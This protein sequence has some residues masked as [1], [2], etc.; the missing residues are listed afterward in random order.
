MGS[1]LRRLCSVKLL[2]VVWTLLTVVLLC[3]PGEDVPSGGDVFF[4]SYLFSL[5]NFDKFVHM[6]LFGG[7]T[8]FWGLHYGFRGKGADWRKVCI[9]LA[10]LSMALGIFLEFVQ[11][12]FIPDRSFDG[13]DIVADSAGA[14]IAALL[15]FYWFP[16]RK[17]KS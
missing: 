5:P 12:F 17:A 1:F 10:G 4:L 9:L 13:L 11:L 15:L 14:I 6:V 2:P 7:I 3:L 16:G 8:Y